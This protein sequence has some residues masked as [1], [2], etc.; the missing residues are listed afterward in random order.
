[1]RLQTETQTV[2]VNKMGDSISKTKDMV[3]SNDK[4]MAQLA[5]ALHKKHAHDEYIS[6]S[7]KLLLRGASAS[8]KAKM[9]N[10]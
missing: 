10:L 9:N 3:K 8:L 2:L 5:P 7:D 1:M 4:M 6:T